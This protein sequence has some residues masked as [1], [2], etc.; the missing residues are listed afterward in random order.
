MN[1]D[2]YIGEYAQVENVPESLRD[3]SEEGMSSGDGARP[4]E[5]MKIP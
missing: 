2:E 1:T 3:P 4:V 5:Q